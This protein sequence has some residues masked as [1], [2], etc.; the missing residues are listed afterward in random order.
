MRDDLV[1]LPP[2]REQT[3]LEAAGSLLFKLSL[4]SGDEQ[5]FRDEFLPMTRQHFE[6]LYDLNPATSVESLE[7]KVFEDATNE[8][9]GDTAIGLMNNEM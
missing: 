4:L 5:K 9:D 7:D 1:K 6:K 8:A 3:Y 2:I